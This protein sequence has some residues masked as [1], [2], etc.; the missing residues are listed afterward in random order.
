MKGT[1]VVIADK[2]KPLKFGTFLEFGVA[3]RPMGAAVEIYSTA[4]IMLD[5]GEI[6]N[7]PVESITFKTNKE[8]LECQQSKDFAMPFCTCCGREL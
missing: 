2:T 8:C 7:V 5:D 6:V 1:K 3:S 4:I